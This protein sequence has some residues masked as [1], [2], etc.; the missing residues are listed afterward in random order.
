VVPSAHGTVRKHFEQAQQAYGEQLW[1]Y[2]LVTQNCQKFVLW[3]LG[4]DVTPEVRQFVEQDI[5]ATLK[6]MGLLQR[7]A[8]GITDVAA[9][10][11]V[12][13]QGAGHHVI[14]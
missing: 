12:A 7:I 1:Q 5:E 13:L 2:H 3:F 10:A 9:T 14:M 4:G 11:D 6:D 8:T